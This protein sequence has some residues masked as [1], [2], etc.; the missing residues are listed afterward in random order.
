MI[1][2][3][4]RGER[5]L[6]L[7]RALP[8]SKLPARL[9]VVPQDCNP[10]CERMIQHPLPDW[11]FDDANEGDKASELLVHNRADWELVEAIYYDGYGAEDRSRVTLPP[12]GQRPL[13]DIEQGVAVL[14]ESFQKIGGAI[15]TGCLTGQE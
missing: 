8:T 13:A 11:V 14:D 12:N 2:F 10:I 5:L 3:E 6:A 1:G 4:D 7:K 9:R 15:V